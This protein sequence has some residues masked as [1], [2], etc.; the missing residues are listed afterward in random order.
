[1]P[2][3]P[4]VVYILLFSLFKTFWSQY[5]PKIFLKKVTIWNFS[6]GAEVE[7]KWQVV[8]YWIEDGEISTET[9]SSSHWW[10]WEGDTAQF[11]YA[12]KRRALTGIRVKHYSRGISFWSHM[13]NMSPSYFSSSA[14]CWWLSLYRRNENE[15]VFTMKSC[16]N[17][18]FHSFVQLCKS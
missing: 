2:L 3:I 6:G 10:N 17:T 16:R 11:F 14:A 9:T 4:R 8:E 7:N 12:G 1:M 5:P 13:K 18:R 15:P